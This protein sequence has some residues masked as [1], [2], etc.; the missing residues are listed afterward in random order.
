MQKMTVQLTDHHILQEEYP[1]QPYLIKNYFFP[2]VL[3]ILT[4]GSQMG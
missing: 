4:V 3:D 2:V 1:S